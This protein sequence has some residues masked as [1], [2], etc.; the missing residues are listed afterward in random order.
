MLYCDYY[1][2]I[3]IYLQRLLLLL[4]QH[5]IIIVTFYLTLSWTRLGWKNFK[6]SKCWLGGHHASIMTQTRTETLA[7]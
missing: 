3:A 7:C 5:F 1:S 6:L 4:L 2:Q